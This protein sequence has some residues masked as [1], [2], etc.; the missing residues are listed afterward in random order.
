MISKFDESELKMLFV[1]EGNSKNGQVTII[2]GSSL[3]HGAPLFSLKVASRIVDMVFFA[4]PEPGLKEVSDNL[5]SDL[6]S[7]IWVPWTEVDD[8]VEKSDSVLIGPGFMRYRTEKDERE[9]PDGT[10]E[11]SE[12]TKNITYGLLKKF[13]DKKWVID[14][15]SLQVMEADM[16]PGNS[17]ITP[18]KGEY[19]RL[20]GD[21]DVSDASEKY[22]CTIL[23]KGLKDL[24]S[25]KG[26]TVSIEGGNAGLSKGGTGDTLAG[27][28]A[29]LYTKNNA[30][31]SASAASYVLKRSGDELFKSVGTNFNADDLSDMVPQILKELQSG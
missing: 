3:F 4:S 13:P 12:F 21:M 31:L 29:A 27:L 9:F 26:K 15:G 16:I 17:I 23:L 2:G 20:F 10:D 11:A 7:F 18:N 19:E 1:P 14:A 25:S 5:K 22:K 6:L 30:Y 8:Y 28:V 24:V